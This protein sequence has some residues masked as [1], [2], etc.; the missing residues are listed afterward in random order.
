MPTIAAS[1][2]TS[3]YLFDVAE[4]IDLERLRQLIGGGAAA[5]RF[6]PKAGTPS[7]FQYSLPPLVVD[8]E[9]VGV[10]PIAGFRARLKFFDYGVI[11][12]A[13]TQ[14]VALRLV[15]VASPVPVWNTIRCSVPP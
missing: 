8:G 11:S 1:T 4:E 3:F 9:A 7:Y 14:P 10:G 5:A 6:V 13:L 15:G 2:I 12:L